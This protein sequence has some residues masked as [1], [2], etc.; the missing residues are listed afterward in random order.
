MKSDLSRDTFDGAK[1][2]TRVLMQ[3]GRV[4]LDADHNEQ[5]AILLHYLWTLA[6]DVIGPAGGPMLG[7]GFNLTAP[8]DANS[9]FTIGKGRYYVDGLLVEN[10]TDALAYASQP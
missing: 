1:H 3:Q 6:A 10:D 2:F 8:A 9:S 4:T 5:V 7:G